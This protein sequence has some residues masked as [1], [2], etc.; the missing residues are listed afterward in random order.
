MKTIIILLLLGI[1]SHSFAQKKTFVR[2]FD[3]KGKKISS[4]HVLAITDDGIILDKNPTPDSIAVA[5]IGTIE[6]RRSIG[7]GTAVGALAGA[8]TGTLLAAVSNSTEPETNSSDWD[9]EII[10]PAETVLGGAVAGAILG[11]V[12]GTVI[13]LF[14][15]RISI[16]VSGDPKN[17]PEVQRV[18]GATGKQ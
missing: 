17:W 13:S 4:G 18:L 14:G 9:I 3:L 7:H 10:T 1:G 2:V 16:K 8:A 15:K 5:A 11:A 6:T 12:T